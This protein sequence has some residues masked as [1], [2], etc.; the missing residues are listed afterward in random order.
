MIAGWRA[1]LDLAELLGHDRDKVAEVT[2]E[3]R[4]RDDIALVGDLLAD[5]VQRVVFTYDRATR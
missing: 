1:G 5:K 2:I 3:V 4:E